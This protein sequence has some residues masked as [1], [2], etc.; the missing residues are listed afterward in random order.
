M[1][2]LYRVLCSYLYQKEGL[3]I[4]YCVDTIIAIYFICYLESSLFANWPEK[5]FYGTTVS[6]YPLVPW[7]KNVFLFQMKR[8]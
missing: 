5:I 3:L 1:Y 7:E 6:G 2:I 4:T 8:C